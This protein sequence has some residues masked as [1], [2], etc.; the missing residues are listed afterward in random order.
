M[1]GEVVRLREAHLY[2]TA[3]GLFNKY[4]YASTSMRQICRAIGIRESSLYHYIRSKEDLLYHIC[5]RSMFLSLEAI[6]PIVQSNCR[7]ELKLKKMIETHITTIAENSN[8]H[9]TMLKELRSLSAS[10]QRKIIKLR[11]RYEALFRKVI[12]D[13]VKEK[14]FRETNVKITTLALLGMMNWLIHW[15]SPDGPMK[16]EEIARIFSDLFLKRPRR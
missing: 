7:P 10:N 15:Y 12:A 8:E 16:S 14:V 4:G 6:E 5:E 13:C 3:P 9:S 11:D 1:P 2:R